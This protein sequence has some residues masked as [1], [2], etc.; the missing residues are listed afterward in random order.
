MR[1]TFRIFFIFAASLIMMSGCNAIFKTNTDEDIK[2][3]GEKQETD[4]P[5]D[6]SHHEKELDDDDKTSTQDEIESENSNEN[7]NENSVNEELEDNFQGDYKVAMGGKMIEE[8][9]KIIIEGNSNLIPGSRLVGEVKI[10]DK[11]V[12]YF[13]NSSTEDIEFLADTTEIVDEDGNFYMEID[14]HGTD[15]ET[16]VSVKF[17]FDGQ[18]DDEVI[19]HYGDRGQK[20][21]GPLVYQ[22][23]GELGGG[24]PDNIFKKAEMSTSFQPGKE[25]A[26]RHFHEPDWYEIP[27]DQGDPRVWIEVEELNDDG[28][29]FYIHGRSNLIEGSRIAIERNNI[30]EAETYVLKDGSFNFKF[31]YE[32]KENSPFSIIFDP[33]DFQWNI[34]EETYG[35]EGQQL[36]GNL[37]KTEAYSNRQIIEYEIEEESQVIEV[38]DNVEM[39]M[40]GSEVTLLVPDKVLFEFDEYKLKDS[41]KSTLKE[42]GETLQNSFNKKDFEIEINGHTDNIGKD[43]YNQKLSENRAN[44]V[45]K[46][47]EKQLD[48]L[49]VTFTTNGYGA[50]KPIASND[51]KAGQ[52]KNRRVEIIIDLK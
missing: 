50:N 5:I 41:S 4:Q 33:H 23:Q 8:E 47:L 29:F 7:L 22:H 2:S 52:A 10:I 31:D 9:D 16:V 13:E 37:V 12:R 45:K 38:P 44:E 1:I 11:N 20:L 35:A 27:E 24:G 40:E 36:I 26:I 42:I 14:H 30:R 49:S 46:Y 18:Q 3:T 19:R 21:E 34:V 6:P 43:D 32:Y 39:V 28:E 51:T 25:K 17:H 15:K 48:T